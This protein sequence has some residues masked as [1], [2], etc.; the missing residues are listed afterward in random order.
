MLVTRATGEARTLPAT[1]D[2]QPEL[3]G[4][5]G[6]SSRLCSAKRTRTRTAIYA[7]PLDGPPQSCSSPPRESR[8]AGR[9]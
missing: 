8:A 4:W 9:A 6:D 1:Y 2:E 3:L 5:Y 7:I